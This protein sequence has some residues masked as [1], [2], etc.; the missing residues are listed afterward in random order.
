MPAPAFGTW[1]SHHKKTTAQ[2]QLVALT[3][4]GK[5]R[6]GL[7]ETRVFALVSLYAF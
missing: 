5:A 3:L 1:Y 7:F 6:A 4:E 2:L